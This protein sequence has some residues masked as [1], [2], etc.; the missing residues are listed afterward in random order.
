MSRHPDWCAGAH[1]CALGEHRSHPLTW[2]TAYG[3]FVATRV[4]TAAG[5]QHLE[6][7]AVVELPDEPVTARNHAL[8]LTVGVDTAVR[9]L[10]AQAT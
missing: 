2:H 8:R 9:A 7:R 4:Q 3:T 5:R 1:R 6:L 10:V